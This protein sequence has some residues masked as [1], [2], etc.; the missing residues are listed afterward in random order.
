MWPAISNPYAPAIP[1]WKSPFERCKALGNISHAAVN[2]F[3]ESDARLP[4]A[5]SSQSRFR[6][7]E[8]CS[9]ETHESQAGDLEL[10]G[11]VGLAGGGARCS[12]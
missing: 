7:G 5:P 8:E 4:A 12:R 1:T 11:A 6:L 2:S 3:V 9:E 10:A